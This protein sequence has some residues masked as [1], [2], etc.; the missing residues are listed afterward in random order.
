M[1][2]AFPVVQGLV[3]EHF[4]RTDGFLLVEIEEGE[5]KSRDMIKAPP[6]EPGLLPRVLMEHKVDCV[7]TGGLGMKAKMMFEQNGVQVISGIC[8]PVEE[9]LGRYMSGTLEPG[10]G[11]CMGGHDTC[12]H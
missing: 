5:L 7:V 3:S 9:V 2:V 4:G 10:D 8:G 6:H 1:K 12:D 11:T